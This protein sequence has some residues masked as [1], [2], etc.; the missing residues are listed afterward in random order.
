MTPRPFALALG[1][2]VLSSAAFAQTLITDDFSVDSS[3]DYTVVDDTTPDGTTNFQFDYVAAGIPLAPRSSG[4]DTKGLRITVNDS[5]GTPDALTAFHNT[6][7]TADRYVMTV[8]VYSAFDPSTSGT[9]E[10]GHVGIGGNGT[11]FNQL[12]S[13][14][15]GSGAFI[16]FTGD[17]GSSSD[18]RW[19][20]DPANT[21]ADET[22]N[23]T[24]PNDHPSYLGHGSNNTG[25][26]FQQL[27]PATNGS[28]GNIWTT[29]TIDVENTI[30][31]ISFYFDGQL[32]FQGRFD[33]RFDGL[34]SL[35]HADTFNSVAPGTQFVVFDNLVVEESGD[36]SDIGANYCT[37]TL[38]T[39]GVAGSI[40]AFGSDRVADNDLT[41]VASGLPVAQAGIFLVG[42]TQVF[43][44]GVNGLSDGNLCIFPVNRFIRPG[45]ILAADTSGTFSLTLD[46]TSVP[47]GS[48][49]VPVAAGSTHYFQAW[50]RDRS[51]LGSNLTDGLEVTFR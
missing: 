49:Y 38:N 2:A 18:Y 11:T 17:G 3:A 36:P 1:G 14:I 41:L 23:T 46:L 40:S 9:T 32:T 4:A 16:A 15:S 5:I 31:R 10:H 6:M 21:P 12:F 22:A 8:D 25:A 34:V 27:F 20:R 45:E 13:P 33:G 7:V 30:G 50:H 26:F 44:P 28:P 37:A 35:G 29:L 19:F 39:T 51:G 43:L 48:S 24:L 47:D 42:S